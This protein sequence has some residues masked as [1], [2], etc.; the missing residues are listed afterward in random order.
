MFSINHYNFVY[1][2][3]NRVRIKNDEKLGRQK[4]MRCQTKLSDLPGPP[5]SPRVHGSII[6]IELFWPRHRSTAL[7]SLTPPYRP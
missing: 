4:V 2:Y 7:P 3:K 1:N 5:G 6:I